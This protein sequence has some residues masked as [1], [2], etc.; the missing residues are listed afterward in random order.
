ML[1]ISRVVEYGSV[2]EVLTYHGVGSGH[3][4]PIRPTREKREEIDPRKALI[5]FFFFLSWVGLALGLFVTLDGF[6]TN[7]YIYSYTQLAE[8][9]F[10]TNFQ[11]FLC[12]P[13]ART[14]GCVCSL[15][16]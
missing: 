10:D 9:S 11:G 8:M 7:T 14:T 15:R 13:I 5:F 2:P 12:P 1:E 6:N 4:D 3:P 16:T